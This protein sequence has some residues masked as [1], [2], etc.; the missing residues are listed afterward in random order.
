M[1]RHILLAASGL[2]NEEEDRRPSFPVGIYTQKQ[3]VYAA[4]Q[5][6]EEVPG[7]ERFP[8]LP[9]LFLEMTT[10]DKTVTYARLCSLLKKHGK[11]ILK[12]SEGERK[13]A[14]WE[15]EP[16]IMPLDNEAVNIVR[17]E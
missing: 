15:F 10:G 13:Y 2:Y 9:S 5:Q 17:E 8:E 12:D 6:L 3:F 16:N 11:L 1:P 4:V 14:L 7:T